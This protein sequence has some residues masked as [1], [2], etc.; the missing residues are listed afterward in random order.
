MLLSIALMT[1]AM[2]ATALL[3]T[4]NMVGP[5]AGWMLLA[6]RCVMGFSVGGEYTGVV[7]YLLEGSPARR[8]GLIPLVGICRKRDWL[9]A[10]GWCFRADREPDEHPKARWMGSGESRS[11]SAPSRRLGRDRAFDDARKPRIPEAEDEGHGARRAVNAC[12]RQSPG[13]DCALLFDLRARFDHLLCRNDLRPPVLNR[14]SFGAEFAL[15]S[16]IAA[17]A[18]IMV[19]P[20]IGALADRIGRK[21]VLIALC[22][23]S[24][25]MPIT[26]FSL[27]ASGARE[28]ALTGALVLRS[29]AGAVSAVG[30]VATAEQFPGEGRGYGTCAWCSDGNRDLRRIHALW[31]PVAG[32]TDRL[33]NGSRDHDCSGCPR[34]SSRSLGNARDKS[35]LNR[36]PCCRP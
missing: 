31:G 13:G 30:A 34:G 19:T 20:V 29:L 6:L 12:P 28:E 9:P 25:A 7:A 32:R 33:G 5:I 36:S 35:S 2:L 27:M 11:L 16:T 8:R 24:A 15:L 10:R 1:A 23:G 17:V 14:P 18:V 21:P 3:P 26:M 4:R 22:V